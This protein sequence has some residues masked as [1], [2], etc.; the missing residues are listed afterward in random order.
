MLLGVKTLSNL[1]SV[2][3]HFVITIEYHSTY[4]LNLIYEV[5][6]FPEYLNNCCLPSFFGSMTSVNS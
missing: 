6:M 2:L 5:G 1:F 3:S 4:C